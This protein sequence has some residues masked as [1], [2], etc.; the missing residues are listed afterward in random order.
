M[1]LSI[2]FINTYINS[3][4]SYKFFLHLCD[5]IIYVFLEDQES[6]LHNNYDISRDHWDTSVQAR[7]KEFTFEIKS[8]PRFTQREVC[9]KRFSL[10][11]HFMRET[12]DIS[13]HPHHN[14]KLPTI[15][16]ALRLQS[17]YK[18]I[19]QRRVLFSHPYKHP[20]TLSRV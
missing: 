10:V 19:G 4:L 14:A 15:P 3:I 9:R 8:I 20:F 17:P 6:K 2:L 7:Q 18:T 12:T 13:L 16:Y 11:F 5:G 1:S